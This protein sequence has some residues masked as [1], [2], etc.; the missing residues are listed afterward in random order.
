MWF[1][2]DGKGRSFVGRICLYLYLLVL[3][4]LFGN[5]SPVRQMK[6]D[7]ASDTLVISITCLLVSLVM[8]L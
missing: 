5:L 2:C 6:S 7:V 4:F 3:P 8:L 1:I